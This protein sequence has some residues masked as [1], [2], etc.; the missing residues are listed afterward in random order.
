MKKEKETMT[1]PKKKKEL[2]LIQTT[3]TT[4]W[5]A[6]SEK[7][8]SSVIRKRKKKGFIEGKRENVFFLFLI[9]FFSV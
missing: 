5:Q 7:K 1:W 9:D 6:R 4:T 3:I 2:E 8:F